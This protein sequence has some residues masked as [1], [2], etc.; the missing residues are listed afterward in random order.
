MEDRYIDF[1]D[2]IS[3]KTEEEGMIVWEP[4]LYE[5]VPLYHLFLLPESFKNICNSLPHP[6]KKV[7][8]ML[9]NIAK[10]ILKIYGLVDEKFGALLDK[11]W[12]EEIEVDCDIFIS[13]YVFTATSRGKIVVDT[14]LILDNDV[15]VVWNPTMKAEYCI[16]AI[17]NKK[18]KNVSLEVFDA[19]HPWLTLDKIHMLVKRT[20]LMIYI[21]SE[22]QTT[23][24]RNRFFSLVE[25]ITDALKKVL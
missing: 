23:H 6:P 13:S 24:I 2:G 10:F 9:A 3:V 4:I 12:G 20:T 17:I 1:V 25:T 11:I 5:Y 18:A 19:Y 14:A 15:L 8:C 21:M 7:P 16:D 22:D